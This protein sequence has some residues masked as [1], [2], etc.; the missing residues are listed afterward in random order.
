MS[1]GRPV[2]A[3]EL[4]AA[5]GGPGKSLYL[6]LEDPS[7]DV[8]TVFDVSAGASFYGPGGAY[9]VFAGKN[10]THGLATTSVDPSQVVGDTSKLTE[11]QKQTQKQWWDKY[12]SKYSVVGYLVKGSA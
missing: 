5:T 9:H 2:K 11:K 8:I 7:S 3:S 4:A 1:K 6:A 10:A 12:M